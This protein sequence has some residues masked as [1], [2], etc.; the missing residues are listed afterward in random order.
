MQKN[1]KPTVTYIEPYYADLSQLLSDLA[2]ANVGK[3][4]QCVS[5]YIAVM[6]NALIASNILTY[7][8]YPPWNNA[9]NPL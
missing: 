5:Y 2:Q 3:Y 1:R 7:F 9:K 6:K 8:G 4:T